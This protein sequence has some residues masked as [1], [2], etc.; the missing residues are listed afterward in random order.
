MKYNN[1]L[2]LIETIKN[3]ASLFIE[4][5]SNINEESMK[6]IDEEV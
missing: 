4:E 3:N 1:K 2:E 6:I 5:Y